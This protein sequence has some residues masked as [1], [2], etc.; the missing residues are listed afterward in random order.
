MTPGKPNTAIL[1]PNNRGVV[2]KN[3]KIREKR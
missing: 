3:G 1:H 2:R